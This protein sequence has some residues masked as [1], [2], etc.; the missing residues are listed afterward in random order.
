MFSEH[1]DWKSNRDRSRIDGCD[2]QVPEQPTSLV[3][4][5]VTL[6]LACSYSLHATDFPIVVLERPYILGNVADFHWRHE[7]SCDKHK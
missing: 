1:R 4:Q 5:P 3:L 7:I 2:R 6:P